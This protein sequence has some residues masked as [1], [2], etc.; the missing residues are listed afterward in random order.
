MKTLPNTDLSVSPIGLGIAGFGTDISELPAFKLLDRFRELGGNFVDSAHCYA[1]WKPGGLG[2]PERTIARY[3]DLRTDELLVGTKGGHCD[4]GPDY[5]RPDHFLQPELVARDIEECLDRLEMEAI[6]LFYLHRDDP[7]V[8]VG[9]I[10]DMLEVFVRRGQ[11]RYLGASNWSVERVAEANAYARANGRYPFVA[12]QN[13]WSLA[14]PTWPNGGVGT[15]RY[16]TGADVPA[17]V[18]LGIAVIPY[19]AAANGYFAGRTVGQFETAENSALRARV[20]AVA[21][22]V[23]ATPTQVTLAWLIAQPLTVIPLVGTGSIEHLEEAFG[24]LRVTL[25]PEQIARLEA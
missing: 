11:V 6:D 12:L 3:R 21:R 23:G 24:A 19:S 20:W 14:K 9:E 7:R 16:L 2:A 13:Q 5:P 18:E 8:P 22:E 1:F 25:T 15:V 17:L 4:A 10:V